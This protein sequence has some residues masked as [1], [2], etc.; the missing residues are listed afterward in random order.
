MVGLQH[1]DIVTPPIAFG[2]LTGREKTD[3]E[4]PLSCMLRTLPCFWRGPLC[5]INPA[6]VSFPHQLRHL[7]CERLIFSI[8]THFF[9]HSLELNHVNVAF[10]YFI[11]CTRY[12]PC[13]WNVIN[14]IFHFVVNFKFYLAC[15]LYK[16]IRSRG[17]GWEFQFIRL[18]GIEKRKAYRISMQQKRDQRLTTVQQKTNFR[19]LPTI[20]LMTTEWR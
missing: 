18:S 19:V 15:G 12:F 4:S 6:W 13:H 10:S 3:F 5:G 17:K 20:S 1:L 7:S 16:S 11:F 14:I 2:P 9:T 8:H